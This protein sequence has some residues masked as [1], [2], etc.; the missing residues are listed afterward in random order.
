MTHSRLQQFERALSKQNRRLT[1]E[2]RLVAEFAFQAQG[3]I[4]PNKL[5]EQI[6]SQNKHIS[7]SAVYRTLLWLQEAGLVRTDYDFENPS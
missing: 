3:P 1:R 6:I 7:R 5:Y 4:T 2:R